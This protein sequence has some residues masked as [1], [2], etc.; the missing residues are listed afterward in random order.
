MNR[1]TGAKGLTD[2]EDFSLSAVCPLAKLL[3]F[4]CNCLSEGGAPLVRQRLPLQW[5][6]FF[7]VTLL[8][9]QVYIVA[10]IVQEYVVILVEVGV[11]RAELN[12][13]EGTMVT[14]ICYE[15]QDVAIGRIT[16]EL[17]L[18]AIL[19]QFLRVVHFR[20]AL[21]KPAYLHQETNS[22]WRLA[23]PY[24]CSVYSLGWGR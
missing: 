2:D 11:H 19:V 20:G 5:F 3:W 15:I 7:I 12:V 24:F 1:H 17:E 9:G 4:M 13:T 14:M 22:V 23:G 8:L 16:Q 10:V 21:C 18:E 6:F